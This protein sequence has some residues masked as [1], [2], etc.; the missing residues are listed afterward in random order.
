MHQIK[1]FASIESWDQRTLNMSMKD[2]VQTVRQ[3]NY[4]C[5]MKG[6]KQRSWITCIEKSFLFHI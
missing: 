5:N 1:P 6:Y 3:S 4:A 2:G